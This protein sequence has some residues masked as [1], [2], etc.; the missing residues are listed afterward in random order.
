M[1]SHRSGAAVTGRGA[2]PGR[3]APTTVSPPPSGQ[4]PTEDT[5]LPSSTLY[6]VLLCFL[7]RALFRLQTHASD[8]RSMIGGFFVAVPSGRSAR[9]PTG[10]P[11]STASFTP[12]PIPSLPLLASLLSLRTLRPIQ[13]RHSERELLIR[14]CA[15]TQR[16]WL[17]SVWCSEPLLSRHG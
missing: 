17:V 11:S 8:R 12:D 7:A 13:Y 14:N 16:Q 5:D 6:S 9:V 1:S 10:A 2:R 4:R 3:E 15:T